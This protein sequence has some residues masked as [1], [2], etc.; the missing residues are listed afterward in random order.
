MTACPQCSSKWCGP[1]VCR[2]T[3]T[4]HKQ[5]ALDEVEPPPIRVRGILFRDEDDAYDYFRQREVDGE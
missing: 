1:I 2:F 4:T 5:A 3:A